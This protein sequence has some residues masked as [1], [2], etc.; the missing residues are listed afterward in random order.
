MTHPCT[1]CRV[2]PESYLGLAAYRIHCA[3]NCQYSKKHQPEQTSNDNAKQNRPRLD[4]YFCRSGYSYP[5]AP[6]LHG[7]G[8]DRHCAAG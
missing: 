7:A 4:A 3:E 6:A 5:V 2:P 8:R 1:T